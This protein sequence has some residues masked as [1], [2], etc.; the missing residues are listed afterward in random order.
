MSHAMPVKLTQDEIHV[1][2]AQLDE[3]PLVPK[4]SLG[5]IG[6]AA[7]LNDEERGRASRFRFE[8]DRIHFGLARGIL[9]SLLSD[10]CSMPPNEIAMRYSPSGK[11]ALAN[12]Q[13]QDLQFNLSHS[14]GLAVF[15][16][17]RGR[18]VGIDVELTRKMK[19]E[20]K[21]VQRFFSPEEIAAYQ[22]LS[23]EARQRGFFNCWARK[24]AFVKALGEGLS[25]PLA[26]FTVSLTPGEPG[27]L[28]SIGGDMA[29]AT[30]WTLYDLA[31]DPGYVCALVAEGGLLRVSCKRWPG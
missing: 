4:L 12:P 5:T 16:F 11:P 29:A 1:W 23:A 30:G 22:A 9:R 6:L 2:H 17:A 19:D 27:R 31:I 13:H 10:Y 25:H 28:L 21:I 7:L 15:A 24:E 14:H 18:R 8:R 3:L 20:D 26:A